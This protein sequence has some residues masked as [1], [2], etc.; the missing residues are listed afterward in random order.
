MHKCMYSMGAGLGQTCTSNSA[1]GDGLHM[2]WGERER[3]EGFCSPCPGTAGRAILLKMYTHH[4]F[5]IFCLTR[6]MLNLSSSEDK[7]RLT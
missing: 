1:H 2:S 5:E 3:Q 4:H 7:L 6:V